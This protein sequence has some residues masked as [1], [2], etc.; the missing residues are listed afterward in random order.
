MTT[1]MN[2]LPGRVVVIRSGSGLFP[3][4][5][6]TEDAIAYAGKHYA[7][8]TMGIFLTEADCLGVF[9][10]QEIR[11]AGFYISAKARRLQ[12]ALLLPLEAPYVPIYER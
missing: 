7:I 12:E 6:R 5:D 9:L 2:L 11:P 3:I 10:R 4:A 1:L 8:T